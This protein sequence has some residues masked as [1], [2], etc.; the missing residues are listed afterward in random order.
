MKLILRIVLLLIMLCL[1]TVLLPSGAPIS[2]AYA[3][4]SFAPL[5]LDDAPCPVPD[6]AAYLPD[7]KGYQDAS[8]SVTIEETRQYDTTIL[9]ARIRVADP[10]QL[11]TAMASN[12]GTSRDIPGA[13]LAKRY[14]AVFAIN[15]DYFNFDNAGYI[16]R[17]GKAYRDNPREGGDVL[18]IDDKGDLTIVQNATS[19]SIAAFQGTVVNSFSFGPA[20]VVNGQA[21][22]IADNLQIA[23]GK[24]TQRM[25][26]GQDG[27]LS[28]LCVATEGPENPGSVGLTLPQAAELMQSLG[29]VTAYNLDGG[30]SSTMVLNNEKINA[31]SSHKVRSICD[32]LYFAT[33]VPAN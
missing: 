10:S 5:P 14:N 24:P 25:M 18:L 7:A 17:Q 32:I 30:S 2:S 1:L 19:E 20:L 11:R 6:P 16:V 29:C 12:F 13:K 9:V 15:G 22:D 31:R 28:Y 33:L 26:I 23:S 27:P 21:A 8:L 4:Q 3:E